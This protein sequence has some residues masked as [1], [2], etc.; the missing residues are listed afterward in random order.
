[1]ARN[2]M[3]KPEFWEDEKLAKLTRD[4]RL[5]FIGMWSNSDDYGVVKGSSVWLKARIYP[6]DEDIDI[7]TFERWLAGLQMFGMIEPFKANGESF[8]HIRNFGKHQ[9]INRP[10]KQRNPEPPSVTPEG[11][12]STHGALTDEAKLSISIREELKQPQTPAVATP[13][14][15][16]SGQVGGYFD[17]IKSLCKSIT[18]KPPKNGKSFNPY[19]WTQQKTNKRGHPGAIELCLTRIAKEWEMIETPWGYIERV[20]SVENQNFNEQEAIEIHDA[21]KKL[22]PDIL[23]ELTGGVIE[24]IRAPG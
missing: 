13:S 11:S 6:Y 1:M 18:Q 21:L 2:R 3:I 14:N 15:H 10:S 17:S 22:Q 12:R 20:Y 24:R 7:E 9:T 5:T 23:K 16:F 8:Y 19:Q 4:A